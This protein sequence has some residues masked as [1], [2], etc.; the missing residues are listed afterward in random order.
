MIDDDTNSS[1]R[2]SIE[3]RDAA[4]LH[5]VP[6]HEDRWLGSGKGC[7]FR[8]AATSGRVHKCKLKFDGAELVVH[9]YRGLSTGRGGRAEVVPL[10]LAPGESCV[11]GVGVRLTFEGVVSEAQAE[12][13]PDRQAVIPKSARSDSGKE[14]SRKASATP[15]RSHVKSRVKKPTVYAEKYAN[16]RKRLEGR[17]LGSKRVGHWKFWNEDGTVERF[18]EYKA[19]VEVGVWTYVIRDAEDV[20]I[21]TAQQDISQVVWHPRGRLGDDQFVEGEGWQG[22]DGRIGFWRH[23]GADGKLAAEGRYD[24]GLRVGAWKF[25]RP[26]GAV[27]SQGEYQAG[28]KSGMWRF[29]SLTG[30]SIEVDF[31]RSR[32][33]TVEWCA[34]AEGDG[35]GD[36]A[37]GWLVDGRRDGRWRERFEG[38]GIQREG[39]YRGGRMD[40]LWRYRREGGVSL[41]VECSGGRQPVVTWQSQGE[42]ADGGKPA[43]GWLVDGVRQGPWQLTLAGGQCARGSYKDGDRCG[44]WEVHGSGGV[45]QAEGEYVVDCRHGPWTFYYDNGAQRALGSYKDGERHG[46]WEMFV[47][48]RGFS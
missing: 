35:V 21:D 38:S 40:G 16:G 15:S 41:E 34:A 43:G 5:Y 32:Q 8:V 1:A 12:A 28:E 42:G 47:E 30:I 26:D 39:E 25:L 17:M 2:F 46:F 48:I 33:A 18:G 20:E 22:G 11:I 3:S 24:D 45:L 13:G 31:H 6:I 44:R 7:D 14:P 19:G 23:W 29:A 10:S 9:Q 37:E 36:S 4:E 27:E